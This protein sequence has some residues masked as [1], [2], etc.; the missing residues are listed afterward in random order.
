MVAKVSVAV[1]FLHCS[2]YHLPFFHLAS[3]HNA[4]AT[5]SGSGYIMEES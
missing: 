4:E 2:C 5:K 3:F 1:A